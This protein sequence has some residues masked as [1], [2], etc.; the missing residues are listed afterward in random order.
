MFALSI[1]PSPWNTTEE[2][3]GKVRR[4]SDPVCLVHSSGRAGEERGLDP[5]LMFNGN[6]NLT[7]GAAGGGGYRGRLRGSCWVRCNGGRFLRTFASAGWTLP[8]GDLLPVCTFAGFGATHPPPRDAKFHSG[9]SENDYLSNVFH[10]SILDA[11][12]NVFD[13]ASEELY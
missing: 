8:G 12:S 5:E 9:H 11:P 13:G 7:T 3:T 10:G 6:R 2:K 4:G 1:T